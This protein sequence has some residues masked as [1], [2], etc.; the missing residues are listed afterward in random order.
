MQKESKLAVTLTQTILEHASLPAALA[1]LLAAKLSSCSEECEAMRSTIAAA[2]STAPL[3]RA[4]LCDLAKT[5]AV[6]PAVE[7]WLQPVLFFK[8][9]H[10]LTTHRVAHLLWKRGDKPGALLLQSRGRLRTRPSSAARPPHTDLPDAVW[11]SAPKRRAQ[12]AQVSKEGWRGHRQ[13]VCQLQAV[14][15][16]EELHQGA[17]E[18]C[19]APSACE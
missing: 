19:L 12:T 16:Q 13:R 1:A 8:G 2:L 17:V 15:P 3:L 9:F 5:V 6:D 14:R 10:A 11:L 4:V 7:A 18:L